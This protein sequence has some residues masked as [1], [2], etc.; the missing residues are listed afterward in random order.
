MRITH[1][2]S[3]VVKTAA[4]ADQTY[5]LLCPDPTAASLPAGLSS[6]QGHGTLPPQPAQRPSQCTR[7]LPLGKAIAKD[8]RTATPGRED[9]D[10][11]AS[12]TQP[13]PRPRT[14][15]SFVIKKQTVIVWSHC[16]FIPTLQHSQANPS[17]KFNLNHLLWKIKLYKSYT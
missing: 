2:T 5:F 10:T 9:R 7:L 14:P 11:G 6:R 15:T 8:S 3:P 17:L 16:V 12:C 13:S 4:S 1:H